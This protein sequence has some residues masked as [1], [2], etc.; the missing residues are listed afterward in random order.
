MKN[1]RRHR[2]VTSILFVIALFC[3]SAGW[4]YFHRL[5]VQAVAPAIATNP[6][7]WASA[8]GFRTAETNIQKNI[9]N[10]VKGLGGQ[11]S[12]QSVPRADVPG[13]DWNVDTDDGDGARMRNAIQTYSNWRINGGRTRTL[14]QIRTDM[15][16][17]MGGVT[18]TSTQKGMF[19][20]FIISQ[21]PLVG[22]SRVPFA[23]P[24]DDRGTLKFFLIQKQCREWV[25]TK[26]L[27]SSGKPKAYNTG[28]ITSPAAYRPGMGLYKGSA[29]ATIIIDIYW[30]KNGNPTKFRVAESNY[31]SGWTQNPAGMIPWSRTIRT[32]RE[33]KSTDGYY[34]VGFDK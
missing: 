34:V 28:I 3:V 13:G 23:V 21:Y 9:V 24:S 12:G 2:K 8:T 6:E 26:V 33:V 32:D 16:N 19:A 15:I 30:D 25:S 29:H 7:G 17:S 27:A 20:D 11:L 10:A 31:G 4:A 14:A 18:Y 22:P 5:T 1:G